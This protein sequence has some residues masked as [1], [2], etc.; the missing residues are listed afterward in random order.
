LQVVRRDPRLFG[1]AGT[2][3]T[4]QAIQQVCAWL[5]T[6]TPGSLANL[7]KR[8]RLRYKR[9][10]EHIH[11]PDPDYLAKAAT[12]ATLVEIGRRSQHPNVTLYLDE[13]TYYRQPTL[14]RAYAATGPDQALAERSTRT[15]TATRLLG[16]LNVADGRV[17]RC[18]Q[19]RL[20]VATFVRFYQD[21]H[22]AYPDAGTIHVI[23][24]NWPVHFHPDLRVALCAQ[25]QH[26]W[27]IYRPPNW[28]TEPS[29]EAIR[30]WGDLQLPIQLVPLPTYASWLNP[31]EKLWR[32][33]KQELLHLHRLADAVDALRQH[34]L[35]YLAAFAAGSQ[36]LLRY[37]G[38]H[39]PP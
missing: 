19:S 38:L 29:P 3:W 33:L 31:I 21:L 14:A 13:L 27:P 37:V 18:Q 36:A 9:A 32:L 17:H 10:R 24:D 25:I 23:Q 4:L 15:N 2:R 11:S 8:L 16:A 34:V 28:P 39:Y 22:R 12:I 30:P 1:I 5:R 20:S 35:T 6:T 7:L 26:P